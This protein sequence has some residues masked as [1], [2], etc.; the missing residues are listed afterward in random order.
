[1]NLLATAVYSNIKMSFKGL[2][3]TTMTPYSARFAGYKIDKGKLSVDLAYKVEN[4]VLTAD[5]RFVIDQLQLGEPVESPDAVHLP[6]KLAV[7]LLKDRNG[8]IDVPLPIT[9]SLDDPQFKIGPIIWHAVL[10][11]FER[12]V[13]APFAALGHLFGGRHGEE[14]KYVDFPAGSADLDDDS[15]EKLGELAKA[16]QERTQLQ[17]DVPIVYSEELDKPVLAKTR[18]D[19]RLLARAHGDKKQ[20]A[21]G[22]T[23]ASQGASAQ[24]AAQDPAL[25]DPLQHYRL[26]LA[27]YQAELGKDA[28]LPA[29]AQAIQQ[30]KSKKDA[31]PVESAI[32][33]LEKAL[34]DHTEVPDIALQELGKRRTRVIQDALLADGGIDASRVFVINGPAKTDNDKVRVEMALK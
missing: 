28:D 12:A 10:N 17:L 8:V 15:K 23:Q 4:R 30:A 1:M 18:L 6:L 26:L 13:T 20:S 16:L 31:P 33:D 7:A 27:E 19:H 29:S 25:A 9:G 22:A 5:Q 3:L 14:M 24:Q 34:I 2:E 21:A 32:P 11:L